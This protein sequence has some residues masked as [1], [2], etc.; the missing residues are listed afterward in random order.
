MNTTPTTSSKKVELSN[1][2]FFIERTTNYKGWRYT[3]GL[4]GNNLMDSNRKIH[5]PYGM[6][7]RDFKEAQKY[8]DAR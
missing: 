6:E 2:G 5:F 1:G 3:E 7:P 8:I 4:F